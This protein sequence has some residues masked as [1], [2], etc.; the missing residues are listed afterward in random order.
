MHAGKLEIFKARCLPGQKRGILPEW[1]GGFP[2][3]QMYIGT[4]MMRLK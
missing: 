3:L 4:T 2:P 1:G